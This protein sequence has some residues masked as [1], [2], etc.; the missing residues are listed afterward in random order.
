MVHYDR[1]AKAWH[2]ITGRAGGAFKKHVL[3]DVL[4]GRMG[5]PAGLSIL[6]LGAGNGYFMPLAL[7]RFSGQEARR[8]V[9]SDQSQ[10][11]LDIARRESHVPQAEY[12]RLDVRARFPFGD[13]DFDLILATMVFN[14][15]SV[16]GMR[17]ALA[18]CRRV[19][20]EPGRLLVTVTHPTFV[21]SLSKRGLLHRQGKGPLTLPSAGGLRLP[22]VMRSQ[23]DYER[24]LRQSGF[25]WESEDV[26]GTPEVRN[27]KP[28]LRQAGNI[29]LALVFGCTKAK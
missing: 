3:N 13:G 11:L 10:A 8:I 17:R 20:V 25:C 7:R 4:L 6:E 28:G 1:I 26:F 15:V 19:L 9:I 2:R 18:E 29:P 22:V 23:D 27:T 24:L 16:G 21:Q 12:V 14:E 5:S